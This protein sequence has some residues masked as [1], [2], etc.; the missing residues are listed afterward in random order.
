MRLQSATSY[1]GVTNSVPALSWRP[2][3]FG[4]LDSDGE[5]IEYFEPDFEVGMSTA[6]A[7]TRGRLSP[8]A[9]PPVMLNDF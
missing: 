6:C 7:S 3:S 9:R 4:T 8:S 2:I 5:I 1:Y